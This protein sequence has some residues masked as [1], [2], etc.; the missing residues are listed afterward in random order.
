MAKHITEEHYE[1]ANDL[2]KVI[3]FINM[4]D[5]TGFVRCTGITEKH[6]ELYNATMPHFR[7]LFKQREFNLSRY[8]NKLQTPEQLLGFLKK[9]LGILGI[10]YEITRF[11]NHTYL[12]L[13]MENKIYREFIYRMQ[14]LSTSSQNLSNTQI[15]RAE[16]G[17]C[18]NV[19]EIDIST[20]VKTLTIYV[21]GC[22][23][24]KEV[25]E[26]ENA[27]ILKIDF[28]HP[29]LLKFDSFPSDEVEGSVKMRFPLSLCNCAL[30]GNILPV[31]DDQIFMVTIHYAEINKMRFNAQDYKIYLD[32][33]FFERNAYLHH[34]QRLKLH[35][36]QIYL[37]KLLL[38]PS[39]TNR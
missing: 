26:L 16:L 12:R 7:K 2:L 27:M 39:Y 34:Y 14:H 4:A 28:Q 38:L 29:M 37:R 1:Y 19:S 13:K 18:K 10:N 5:Y 36:Y 11:D 8:G 30:I 32:D 20:D 33:E 3:G 25:V 22:V 17:K 31:R 15:Q 6:V 24:L 35:L 23:N 21:K 9:I